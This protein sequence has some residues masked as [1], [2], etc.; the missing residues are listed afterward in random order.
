MQCALYPPIVDLLIP[1]A[2]QHP[3]EAFRNVTEI[4]RSHN[5]LCQ[6]FIYTAVC[7]EAKSKEQNDL[8]FILPEYNYYL[9]DCIITRCIQTYSQP[10]QCRY[11]NLFHWKVFIKHYDAL[12]FAK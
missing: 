6:E 11:R 12:N 8:C 5:F 9:C 1:A 2:T 3:W 10:L 4:N 7:T